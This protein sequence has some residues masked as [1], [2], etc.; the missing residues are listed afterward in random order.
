[1]FALLETEIKDGDNKNKKILIII[2]IIMIVSDVLLFRSIEVH[3]N[4]TLLRKF[5][6][7]LTLRGC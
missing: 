1:V 7:A 3:F 6:S 4:I 2:L 5:R